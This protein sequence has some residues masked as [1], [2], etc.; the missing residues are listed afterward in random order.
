MALILIIL[1]FAIYI[2]V[3]M[4]LLTAFGVLDFDSNSDIVYDIADDIGSAVLVA[5][6]PF[7]L[8]IHFIIK[9]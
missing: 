7:T 1:I 2:A 5:F 3:G 9:S 4:W 8:A 6:W